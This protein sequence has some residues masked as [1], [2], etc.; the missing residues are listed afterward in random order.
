M[1]KRSRILVDP[2]VQWAIVKRI[3]FHWAMFLICLVSISVMVRL[4]FTT[5]ELP[6][7]QTLADACRSQ[8]P[9]LMV[10]AILMPVFLRDTLKMS[11]RFAGPMYRLRTALTKMAHDES[12]SAIKFRAGD[13][14]QEVA[15]DFNTVAAKY[16]QAQKRNAKLEAELAQLRESQPLQR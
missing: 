2:P 16:E 11:N 4:M 13:F 3:F 9:L 1:S 7:A 10:M 8:L 6:F 12:V 15:A 14:W 5:G